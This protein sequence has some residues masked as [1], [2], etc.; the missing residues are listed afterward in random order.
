M[1]AF[2][3]RSPALAATEVLHGGEDFVH[4]DTRAFLRFLLILVHEGTRKDKGHDD[5]PPDIVS[6]LWL[7]VAVLDEP[8]NR[9]YRTATFETLWTA[10]PRL[11]PAGYRVLKV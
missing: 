8:V 2:R 6:S 5:L 7:R 3:P 10:L 4:Q 1:L 9:R 11:S